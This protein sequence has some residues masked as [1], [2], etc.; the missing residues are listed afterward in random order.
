MI[1]DMLAIGR[2]A[3]DR[4]GF[5]IEPAEVA[6]EFNDIPI[7]EHDARNVGRGG[8]AKIVDRRDRPASDNEQQK[9]GGALQDPMN[10]IS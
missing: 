6:I 5:F 7:L 3:L 2:Y 1:F 4:A 8:R 10:I 9:E